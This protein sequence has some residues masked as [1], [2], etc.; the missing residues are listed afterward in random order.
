MRRVAILS[1][2]GDS[3]GMN[4]TIYSFSSLINKK[5]YEVFYIEDGY[6]GFIEGRYKEINLDQLKKE[7]YSPGTFIGSSR[8][9]EFRASGEAREKGVRYLKEK[10][11]E[12]LVIL[13]GNGSYEGGKLISQLGMPVILLP[14]TI[15]NDVTSTHYTI[16]FFSSLEEIFQAIKKIWYTAESHSQ[17]TFVEV[18]GRDCSD[19]AVLAS[20]ASPL[21]DYVI[22]SKNV[23]NFQELKQKIKFLR[24]EKGRKG[25]VIVI[26][27]KILGKEVL[28]SME[29]LTKNL[30]KELSF[31]IRGC[32]LGHVQRGAIPTSWELFVSSQFGKEAFISFDKKE[33]DIAI[34][35]DGFN[36][37]RTPI[38]EL[39]SNSKGDRMTLIEEKNSLS[40]S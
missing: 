1:S 39:S 24:E 13:G 21:V 26:A 15:D 18:M 36:F 14:A 31:T 7:V 22:T 2:G 17:L 28:P 4:S 25:I 3:P 29:E 19:L 12:A 27:E 35:F 40:F 11:I 8:S 9:S 33:F 23:P 20:T 38:S 34:G 5:G 6:Q 32:V 16:G 37:Y 30:E 10:N